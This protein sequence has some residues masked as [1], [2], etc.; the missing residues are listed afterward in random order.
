MPLRSDH[1][2]PGNGCDCAGHSPRPA[3]NAEPGVWSAIAP[4][5][6][7]AVCPACLTTYGKILSAFGVGVGITESQHGALLVVAVAASLASSA[8]RAWRT[9][10]PWPVAVAAL[11][12]ALVLTGHGVDVHTVEWAGILVLV[13]GGVTEHVKLRSRSSADLAATH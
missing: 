10:R 13:V 2:R 4:A 1:H 7:C 9:R 12:A 11:G 8:W 3:S 5:L 6:A